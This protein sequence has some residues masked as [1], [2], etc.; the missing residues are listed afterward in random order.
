MNRHKPF[1]LSVKGNTDI[2][3]EEYPAFYA[4]LARLHRFML[5]E[6]LCG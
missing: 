5:R 2:T 1:L 4:M 3:P 6:N